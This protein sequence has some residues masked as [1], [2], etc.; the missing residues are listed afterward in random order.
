MPEF[1]FEGNRPRVHPEAFVAPTAVLIGDVEVAAGASVWFGAVLRADEAPIR[2]GQGSNVQDNAVVHVS[3]DMPT[4]VGENVTIGHLVTIEGCVVED[5]AMLGMGAVMLQRSRLG[6]G[7]VLA[8]GA[9][10]L[11]GQEIP[12]G[13]LA[14][15]VPAEVKKQI[16]GDSRRW[17][18]FPAGHYQDRARRYRLG[19]RQVG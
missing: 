7:S 14:A 1:E 19:L 2:I 9:L 3:R 10:A 16:S 13:V 15:G 17:V 4:L 12:A 11:Q 6:A 5:E 18:T 8:A